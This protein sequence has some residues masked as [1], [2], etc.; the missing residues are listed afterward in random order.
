LKIEKK[1]LVV[2]LGESGLAAAKWLVRQGSQVTVSEVR[3][4][5]DFN[6][7]VVADL[8]RSGVKLEF[9]GHRIKSFLE[10]DL[11]VVSPGI[12]LD[13]RPLSQARD[14]GIPII[15]EIELASRYLKHHV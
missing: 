14:Q 10:S 3:K 4:K 13:I 8:L 11:I 6:K 7:D 1:V 15:G 2:G 5:A 12:S 9:G